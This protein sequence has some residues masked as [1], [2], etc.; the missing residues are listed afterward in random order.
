MLCNRI[1][2]FAILVAFLGLVIHQY[3]FKVEYSPEVQ[4]KQGRLRGFVHK[5]RLNKEF[6]KF[7]G[8]P[9]ATAPLKELRFKVN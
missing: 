4:V 8:I 2:L 6:Y 7:L 5:S 9:Y 3:F 1:I